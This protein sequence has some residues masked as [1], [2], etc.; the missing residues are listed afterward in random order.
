M[1]SNICVSR[2][3]RAELSYPKINVNILRF[4]NYL[5]ASRILAQL[6][7]ILNVGALFACVVIPMFDLDQTRIDDC[8]DRIVDGNRS[9][10][11]LNITSAAVLCPGEAGPNLTFMHDMLHNTGVVYGDEAA[12]AEACKMSPTTHFPEYFT[13][14]MLLVLISCAVYQMMISALKAVYLIVLSSAYLII[15]HY[16]CSNMFDNQDFLLQTHDG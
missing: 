1:I 2:E 12:T 16:Y 13:Y 6:L 8:V 11:S 7:G 14:S 4:S 3:S 15:V 9:A 5:S 10:G